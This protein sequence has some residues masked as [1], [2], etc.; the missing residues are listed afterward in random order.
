[1]SNSRRSTGA[2]AEKLAAYSLEAMTGKSSLGSVAS[3]KC[4]RPASTV[5]RPAPLSSVSVTSAPSGS[6]RTISWQRHGGDGRRAGAVDLCGRL[7]DDLDV[8]VG[9]AERNGVAL[10][11]DQH[12]RE[13]RDRVPPLDHRLRLRD[14]PEKRAAFDAQF[15]A[16]RS[17]KNRGPRDRETTCRAGKCNWF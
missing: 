1:L 16:T 14:R 9:G 12:V 4:D 15:H 17:A 8:E 2:G 10:G 5:R 13:D 3:E 11:L 7:V 6:L